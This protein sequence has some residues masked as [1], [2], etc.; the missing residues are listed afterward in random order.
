LVMGTLITTRGQR[1]KIM[2]QNQLEFRK[3]R[4]DLLPSTKKYFF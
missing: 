4:T 3:K 1:R 2:E